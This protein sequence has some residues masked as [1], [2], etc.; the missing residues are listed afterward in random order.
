MQTKRDRRRIAVLTVALGLLIALI[1]PAPAATA[2]VGPWFKPGT[3]FSALFPDPSLTRFGP[4]LWAYST[5]QGGVDLPAMW[6]ADETTF[7]ARVE[8]D[9]DDASRDGDIGYFNDAFPSVPWGV[10]TDPCDPATPPCDPKELWAPSVGLV[11]TRWM[12]YHA[13]QVAP[14]GQYTSYGRFCIYVSTSASPMGPFTS[15]SSTPIACPSPTTDPGGAI[16]PDVFSDESSGQSYLTWK[17]EGGPGTSTTIH[18]AQLNSAGT[19]F[20]SATAHLLSATGTGWEGNIIENPSM[21]KYQG[22]W[23]LLYSANEFLSTNY[24]VG[25]A[26]CSGPLGPCTRGSNN[27]ILS[28]GNGRYGPGGADAIVDE[29][30]HLVAAY[31][32]Y[33]AHNGTLGVGLRRMYMAQL[34]ATNGRLSVARGLVDIGAERDVLWDFRAGLAHGSTD[35]SVAISGTY[36]PAVDDFRGDGRDDIFWYGAWDR[37]DAVWSGTASPGAFSKQ[38]LPTGGQHG[39]FV[40]VPGDFNGD[41][42]GDVFWYQPGG[43]PIVAGTCCNYEPH[44]RNDEL[45]FGRADGTFAVQARSKTGAAIPLPGDFDGNGIDDILW[46]APGGE[47]D[48]LWLFTSSGTPLVRSISVHGTYRPIVGDYNGDGRSDIFWYGPGASSDVLWTFGAGAT[49]TSTA[50]RVNGESYRPFSGNFDSDAPD[51]IFWYA[52][53]TT[54]D[55][56][57]MSIN[58]NGTF[59]YAGINVEGNYTPVTGDYDGNGYTDVLWYR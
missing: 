29:R 31:A 45:W 10:V 37:T 57:W 34:T 33:N 17:T 59:T 39:A 5:N 20:V 15:A 28:S 32:A 24:A 23:Y 6:S 18:V 25:Y 50:M 53:G 35:T 54:R 4:M 12:G 16:D 7:T 49:H 51:E 2:E 3:R 8:Y 38:S 22:R 13:V 21:V 11:G 40:P 52:P 14:R 43:N 9:G 1:G 44:A 30:G 58:S 46:Y 19:G 56:M 48:S 27:P 42:R 47:A 55:T 26:T 36:T 41:G